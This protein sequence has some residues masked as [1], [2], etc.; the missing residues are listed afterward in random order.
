RGNAQPAAGQGRASHWSKPYS[1][2]GSIPPPL[3]TEYALATNSAAQTRPA[4]PER[5]CEP[6]VPL[7][8]LASIQVYELTKGHE[9]Q[10]WFQLNSYANLRYNHRSRPN[11]LLK[12]SSPN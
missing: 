6:S 4:R 2:P 8:L 11:A 12:R 1:E 10:V 5:C 7:A 3:Q 9:L